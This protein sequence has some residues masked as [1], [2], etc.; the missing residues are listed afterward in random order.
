MINDSDGKEI[1]VPHPIPYQGSK[2]YLAPQ[3]LQYFP[4]HVDNFFEPFAGSSA[5]T[6]AAAATNVA[7]SYHINDL[8][9]PLINLWK[10]IVNYP[11]KVATKYRQVWEAQEAD[12]IDHYYEIRK[13]FN[14]T[15]RSDYLLYLLTRCVKSAVRYNSDGKFNQSPDKRRVGTDPELLKTRVFRTSKLLK[16]KTHFYSEDYKKIIKKAKKD[17]LI[18]L[19]P[20]Y[21]GVC[22]NRNS[23]YFQGVDFDDLVSALEELNRREVS[24]LVSYDGKTGR[25]THGKALPKHLKLST[26]NLKAGRSSQATLLGRTSLIYESLY[27]SRTLSKKIGLK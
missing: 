22:T 24:F 8:N 7:S 19:D 21:Q 1:S 5:I 10:A 20:P 9:R 6:L 3:I 13:A 12:S 26:V 18:Y 14:K 11:G 27:I 25:K 16:G 23:R 4:D 15:G 2:R 17:D